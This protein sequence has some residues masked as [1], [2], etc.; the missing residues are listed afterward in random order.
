MAAS[1]VPI[2]LRIVEKPCGPAWC[3]ISL[4][5]WTPKTIQP[6][7]F[8]KS[9]LKVFS[10]YRQIAKRAACETVLIAAPDPTMSVMVY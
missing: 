10:P 2:S 6:A 3:E 5:A 7:I 4:T 1:S 8:A 9:P